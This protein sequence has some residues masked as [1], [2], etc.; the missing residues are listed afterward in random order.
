MPHNL[1]FLLRYGAE[2]QGKAAGAMVEKTLEQM[3]RG[4]LQDHIGGGFCRYATDAQ[5]LAPHFEKMLYDNALLAY[6]YGEAYRCT[7]RPFYRAV[8]RRTIE[9][10]L[11]ELWD[12]AGGF[13]CGQ[14]ADSEG[15]EGKYYLLTP[16][17]AEHAL[18]PADGQAFCSRYDV[19]PQGNFEGGSIPN[20]LRTAA[21]E[22]EPPQAEQ[23]RRTL[24][25]YRR[26]RCPLHRDDKVLTAWNGLMI[27]AL[28][29]A[30]RALQEPAY[31]R[32][33][34]QAWDFIG[35]HL[36]DGAGGLRVRWRQG[37]AA[38]RG[39]L[40]DYAF[41]AW[42]LLE[43]YQAGHDGAALREAERIARRMA[44]QFW[45]EE[46]GG[47][48]LTAKDGEQLIHRPKPVHDGAMPAGNSV[49][50]LVL[51]R[52]W[53]LTG[54]AEWH[55]L[56]QAQQRFLA[57][58]EG[59]GRS[60]GL[61]AMLEWLEPPAVLV[62]AQ[63]GPWPQGLDSL[64][65]GWGDRVQTLVKRRENTRELAELAPFTGD[66]PLPEAGCTYY[67]CRHGACQAPV[68]TVEELEKLLE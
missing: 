51:T 68:T 21:W 18:G 61:L 45:D 53:Q 1:L 52:L 2:K 47:F 12:E 63:A 64:L 24:L 25:E 67:L 11:R 3:A 33:A 41:V 13:Y 14:D 56:A 59:A 65:A 26:R 19:T 37:E 55:G 17:D 44:E 35:T 5:W 40:D 58:H 48:F 27:A 57:G 4:G 34:Q 36:R 31:L 54:R 16:A 46:K 38:G 43:M 22:Q 32:A 10:V 39:Q 60:M 49:A 62:V 7:G 23:W 6:A 28:A 66:Y 30:A 20:L 8:C 42:G 29:R 15:V 9:Y 50:A